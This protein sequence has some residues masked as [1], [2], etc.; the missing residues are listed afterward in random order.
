M[1]FN[2]YVNVKT[3]DLVFKLARNKLVVLT[4]KFFWILSSFKYSKGGK[5]Y[6][7]SF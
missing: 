1:K 4:D 6:Q 2:Y 3:I 7:H 5:F